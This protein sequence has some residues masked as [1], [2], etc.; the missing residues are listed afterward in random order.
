MLLGDANK[1]QDP[2]RFLGGKES[3]YLYVILKIIVKLC[4]NTQYKINKYKSIQNN[5]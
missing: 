1:N 2:S 3:I 4:K 5:V